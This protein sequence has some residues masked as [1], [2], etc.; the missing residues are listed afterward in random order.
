MVQTGPDPESA[1]GSEGWEAAAG[2]RP[3]QL[4]A[5]RRYISDMP[6]HNKNHLS[7]P[8][9]RCRGGKSG[10]AVRGARNAAG[11]DSGTPLP[12]NPGAPG[13]IVDSA[14]RTTAPCPSPIP[15]NPDR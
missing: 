3:G 11:I 6:F 4:F 9:R 12:L 8:P 10:R 14:R 15:T 2:Q 7:R 5:P 1:A 13:T